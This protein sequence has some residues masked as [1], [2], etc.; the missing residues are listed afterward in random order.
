MARYEA[1]LDPKTVWVESALIIRFSGKEHE[2]PR[3]NEVSLVS[4][5]FRADGL[6]AS[7]AESGETVAALKTAV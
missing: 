6:A 2:L 4:S 5:W 1:S 7:R 3:S